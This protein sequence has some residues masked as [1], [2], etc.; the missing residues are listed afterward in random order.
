LSILVSMPF[1]RASEERNGAGA[2][3]CRISSSPSGQ[4]RPQVRTATKAC[5]IRFNIKNNL[6]FVNGEVD[7]GDHIYHELEVPYRWKDE[8]QP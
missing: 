7:F 8:E 2:G 4:L 1:Q 5:E 3:S 6:L